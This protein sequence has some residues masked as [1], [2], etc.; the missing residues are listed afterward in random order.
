MV[1]VEVVGGGCVVSGGGSVRVVGVCVKEAVQLLAEPFLFHS[2]PSL[3]ELCLTV[4]GFK[5]L[6][7]I[8]RRKD[9]H[10]IRL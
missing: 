10:I 4:V 6:K 3:Q 9:Y 1:V 8:K 5:D 7:E 2:K